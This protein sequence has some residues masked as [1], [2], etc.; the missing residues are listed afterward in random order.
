MFFWVWTIVAL[1]M[2]GMPGEPGEP[3]TPQRITTTTAPASPATPN[4]PN[5]PNSPN[6]PNAPGSPMSPATPA[7]VAEPQVP[8][9]RFTTA[10]EVKPILTAT[11]GSWVAVREYD[12]KDLVY[13]TQILSWRCGLAGMSLSING[14]TPEIWDMPPCLD[15]TATPNAITPDA[16][17]YRSYPLGS[18]QSVTVGVTYDDL[19]TDSATFQRA[20]VLLP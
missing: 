2:L 8:S 13:V 18:V 14:G 20:Q 3:P 5:S 10:V 11:K 7:I 4:A 1:A 15:N 17:I 9:G 6:A 19:T 16:V 12:G